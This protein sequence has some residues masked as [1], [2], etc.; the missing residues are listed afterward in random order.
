MVVP[1]YAYT[2]QVDEKSDIYSY[3]VVL[4]ELLTGKRPIEPEFGESVNIVEWVKE[5]VHSRSEEEGVGEVLDAN[6][7]SSLSWVREEMT[8]VLRVALLCTS[9]PPI[10]RPSMRD[11]VTMLCEAKPRRKQT[12]PTQ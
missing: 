11:V 7:G 12:P 4:L 10:E 3:G 9:K 1:E 6:I 5:K 8:L 2:M